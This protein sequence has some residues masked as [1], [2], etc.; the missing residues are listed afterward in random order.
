MKIKRL[1]I[2]PVISFLFTES[3]TEKQATATGSPFIVEE[4]GIEAIS[5]AEYNNTKSYWENGQLITEFDC[6]DARIFPPINIKLWDKI[7]VVNGRL[8][9]YAETKNGTSIHHYGEKQSRTVK[10]YNMTLPKL[11]YCYSPSNGK[12][13][14]VV[15]IQIVQFVSDTVVGYRYLTGGCGGSEYHNYHFLT[16]DEVKKVVGQ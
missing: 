9:T 5:A 3:C 10:P 12:E 13:E 14:L 1:F 6:P 8:P 2:F 7:P 16:D 11:A 4:K 15:V